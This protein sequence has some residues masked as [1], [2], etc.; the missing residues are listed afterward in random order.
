M[1]KKTKTPRNLFDLI[2]LRQI[3]FEQ[4]D[5]HHVTLLIPKFRKGFLAYWLQP[6]LRRPLFRIK[7]DD[8]GSFVWL[9]CDGVN[10]VRT[11]G[12]EMKSHFGEAAEPVYDRISRFLQELELSDFVGFSGEDDIMPQSS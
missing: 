9:R 10:N 2:P 12:E 7:L 5:S 1:A 6:R 8:Y 3:E 4:D 11:I